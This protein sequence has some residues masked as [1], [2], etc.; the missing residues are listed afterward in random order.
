MA[1]IVSSWKELSKLNKIQ[2]KDIRNTTRISAVSGEAL[3]LNTVTNVVIV[4]H[5]DNKYIIFIDGEKGTFSSSS[6]ILM[7]F[8][9]SVEEELDGTEDTLAIKITP[10]ISAAG[11]RYLSGQLL[12]IG[13]VL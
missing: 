7:A 2:I 5:N 12:G 4:D 11:K 6:E 13:N 10:N 3:E 9:E 1:T 8:W